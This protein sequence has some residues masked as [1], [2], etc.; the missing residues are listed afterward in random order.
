VICAECQKAGQKSCVYPGLG[1]TTAMWSPP[2]YDE[3]GLSHVHDRNVT[4]TAYRCSNG[5]KWEE[6]SGP[7]ACWCGWPKEAPK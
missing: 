1:I 6:V 2:Y 3:E 5:H 7:G 4:T